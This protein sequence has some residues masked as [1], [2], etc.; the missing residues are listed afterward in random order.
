MVITYSSDMDIDM[1]GVLSLHL[2]GDDGQAAFLSKR[3]L[4]RDDDV[5]RKFPPSM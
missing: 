1:N 2:L 5:F 4:M 3:S